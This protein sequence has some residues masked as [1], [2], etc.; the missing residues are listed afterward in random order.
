MKAIVVGI[1]GVG[2]YYGVKLARAYESSVEH[3]VVFIARGRHLEAIEERGLVVRTKDEGTWTARPALAT[4]D[5]AK[6]GTADIILFC[7][8]GYDLEETAKSMLP[9]INDD[10]VS[11]P[12]LNGTDNPER[13]SRVI[14]KGHVLNGCVYISSVRTAPGEVTQVGGPCTLFF[15]PE[16]G[17]ADP[18]L[19]VETFLKNAGVK[20]SLLED[21]TVVIWSKYLFV[22]PLGGVTSLFGE[23]VGAVLENDRHRS[24]L[25][26][27]MK[28]VESVA[29]ALNVALPEDI[30]ERSM[31]MAGDFPFETKTS[32][33]LDFE[34]S[35]QTE[36]E[37]FVGFIVKKSKYLG[38][39]TPLHNQVYLS[40]G[41]KE[42]R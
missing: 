6:A 15:G 17:A 23:P 1:G 22:G 36:L 20:A 37:T 39:E 21:I 3:E 35:N 31:K 10:T 12:L 29:R 19:P 14:K 27:M 28:E 40:L 4:G 5:P 30:V 33:Q 32:I 11:I 38:I 26:G 34:R 42:A 7:V 25:E 2:G 24:M 8:K 41:A 13:L 18:Y 9:C 16:K